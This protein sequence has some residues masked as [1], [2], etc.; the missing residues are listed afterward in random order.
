MHQVIAIDDQGHVC[1]GC[2]A[3]RAGQKRHY[4]AS[5]RCPGLDNYRANCVV[6]ESGFARKPDQN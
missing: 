4:I 3:V 5:S 2:A 1:A 6:G